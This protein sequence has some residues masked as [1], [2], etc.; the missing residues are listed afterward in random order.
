MVQEGS[1]ESGTRCNKQT[2]CDNDFPVAVRSFKFSQSL[3]KRVAVQKF[4]FI[5]RQILPIT[6]FFSADWFDHIIFFAIANGRIPIVKT[7][8]VAL[9]SKNY[10]KKAELL[11]G[12]PEIPWPT[13][14]RPAAFS[15]PHQY[16]NKRI[17]KRSGI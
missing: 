14:S 7:I 6:L 4:L 16:L 2:E 3:S 15:G 10:A 1:V 5:N 8:S 11:T 17:S 9:N 12:S 13:C